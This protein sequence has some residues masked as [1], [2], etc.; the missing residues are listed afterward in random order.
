MGGQGEKTRMGKR[1]K[2]T[3]RKGEGRKKRENILKRRK[4]KGWKRQLECR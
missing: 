1:G 3:D 2:A 4:S